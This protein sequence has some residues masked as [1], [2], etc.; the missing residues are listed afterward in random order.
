MA[1]E[2]RRLRPGSLP[3]ALPLGSFAPVVGLSVAVEADLANR[4]DVDNVVNPPVPGPGQ[5]VPAVLAGGGVHRGGPGPGREPVPV[6]EP[7]HVPDVGQHPGGD[8]RA[9]TTEVH[10]IDPG[11]RRSSGD[12]SAASVPDR[13]HPGRMGIPPTSASDSMVRTNRSGWR[14]TDNP[15][16]PGTSN[17]VGARAP[18]RAR[19]ARRVIHVEAFAS[20]NCLVAVDPDGP[21]HPHPWTGAPDL[22]SPAHALKSEEPVYGSEAEATLRL[23][24]SSHCGVRA[25]RSQNSGTNRGDTIR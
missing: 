19:G 7:G 16:M 9:D 14:S 3:A 5:P 23:S 6:G 17:E 15:C 21:Q 11:H 1:S 22:I 12:P 18:E 8:H 25:S 10:Q 24:L 13:D 2:M 4:G 20:I